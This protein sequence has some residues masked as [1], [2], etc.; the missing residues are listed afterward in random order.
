M[1]LQD[2]EEDEHDPRSRANAGA[3]AVDG[4]G[5]DTRVGLGAESGSMPIAGST[6]YVYYAYRDVDTGTIT[7]RVWHRATVVKMHRSSPSKDA[8]TVLQLSDGSTNKVTL[9]HNCAHLRFADFRGKKLDDDVVKF[10]RSKFGKRRIYNDD[11]ALA[12]CYDPKR[13]LEPQT[14]PAKP[15]DR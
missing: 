12:W 9:K 4:A 14:T 8:G 3:S 15:H 6:V 10:E 1:F 13:D 11:S 5:A 7:D 2:D